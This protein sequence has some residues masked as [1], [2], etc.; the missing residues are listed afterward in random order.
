M[1]G[2][3]VST[4]T[5][6]PLPLRLIALCLFT[7][8]LGLGFLGALVFLDAATAPASTAAA[9]AGALLAVLPGRRFSNRGA[10]GPFTRAY[11][12][13]CGVAAAGGLI[14]LPLVDSGIP[15]FV[16]P[17]LLGLAAGGSL[18][19]VLAT[20]QSLHPPRQGAPL[21]A[22]AGASFGMGGLI[23]N[24]L[25]AAAVTVY[26]T[27]GLLALAAA[28]PALMAYAAV[29]AGGLRREPVPDAQHGIGAAPGAGT[30][31]VLLAASLLCQAAACGVATCWMPLYF[32]RGFGLSLPQ[33]ALALAGLWLAL[34]FG[35]V[36]GGRVPRGPQGTA[37]LWLPAAIAPAGALLMLVADRPL[38]AV[39]GSGILGFGM[40]L[41]LPLTLGLGR[42]PL[43]KG[44]RR[45]IGRAAHV[46]LA[47]S[48]L[49]G[50]PAA[51]LAPF[52]SSY[53]VLTVL[54]CFLGGI[55]TL[56]VLVGDFR[57]SG[58]PAVV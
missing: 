39:L 33:G 28:V 10:P 15:A 9:A 42:W 21:L 51:T 36:S 43:T 34:A 35:W 53:P 50:W 58:D 30:R 14:A 17:L 47:A 45:W 5:P 13:A 38:A 27:D 7:L 6:G 49:A 3:G 46:S 24:L 31:S 12:A 25:V 56:A 19:L 23:A 48:L 26:R 18:R 2:A 57:L 52:G 44:P 20:L 8:G 4:R 37:P 41:L 11:L 40:G 1:A 32:A 16:I 55:G 29:Q 54:A 22:L